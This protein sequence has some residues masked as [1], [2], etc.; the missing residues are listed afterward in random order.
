[1]E[2]ARWHAELLQLARFCARPLFLRRGLLFCVST[3]LCT[4]N[5]A[6]PPCRVGRVV[7]SSWR[8]N[9]AEKCGASFFTSLLVDA[10]EDVAPALRADWAPACVRESPFGFK[11]WFSRS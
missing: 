5:L 7:S 10:V 6:A 1:M 8:R 9:G 3:P 11:P 4:E 2:A